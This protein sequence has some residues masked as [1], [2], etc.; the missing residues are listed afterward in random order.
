MNFAKSSVFHRAFRKNRAIRLY[1]NTCLYHTGFF[2]YLLF[3]FLFQFPLFYL[4]ESPLIVWNIP[5]MGA[6]F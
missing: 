5:R 4:V 3:L 1:L 2:S 6:F